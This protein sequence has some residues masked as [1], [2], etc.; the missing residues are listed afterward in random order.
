MAG[1][2]EP[3]GEMEVC[4]WAVKAEAQWRSQEL[5]HLS[6]PLCYFLSGQQGAP[7]QGQGRA[8]GWQTLGSDWEEKD[9]QKGA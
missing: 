8:H 2:T 4:G 6:S 1:A 7:E 9:P 5:L 3:W